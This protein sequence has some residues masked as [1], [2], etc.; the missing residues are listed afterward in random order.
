MLAPMVTALLGTPAL[1]QSA[2]PGPGGGT[3]KAAHSGLCLAV[4]AGNRA[5]GAAVTQQPCTGGDEQIWDTKPQRSGVAYV[6]RMSGKC[7]NVSGLTNALTQA[8]TQVFQ[9]TCAGAANDTWT[10]QAQTW[11]SGYRLVA[12]VSGMCLNVSGAFTSVGAGTIQWP[13]VGAANETFTSTAAGRAAAPQSALPG[14]GGGTLKAAHSG[15]CLAVAAGNR[16]DGA[17]ITQQPCTG[18]DEQIW[19]TKPQRSGVAY[20]NRMSGK[21]LNVSGLTNALTQAGTQ[22]FQWTCAGAANDTWTAQAQTWGSG[23]R[24][25]A[26]VSGM[27]LNVN[28]AF[29]SVGAGTIQWPCVGAVNETFSS[30]PAAGMGSTTGPGTGTV[31]GSGSGTGGGSTGGGGGGTVPPGDAPPATTGLIVA[32]HSAMC[33]EN[34]GAQT[35][36]GVGID[37]WPCEPGATHMDWTFVPASTGYQIRN[38]KSGLCLTVT[39]GATN[40]GAGTSQQS[41]DAST[42][43]GLW[44]LRKVGG[45]YEIVAVHSGRCLTVSSASR[46]NNAAVIQWDCTLQD[47]TVFALVPPAPPSAWTPLTTL[48]LV[49]VSATVMPSGKVMLWAAESRTSFGSGNGTWITVYDPGT[50]TSNDTYVSNTNHDMFCVGT[51]LLPDGRMMITGGITAGGTSLYNPDTNQWSTGPTLTIPRGYN[52]NVTLSTGETMTYGGSWSG[53]IG[54]KSAEVWSA[55]ARSWRVL[56]NVSGDAAAEPGVDLYRADNH[57]WLFGVSNGYVFHAGPSREMHW[58]GTGGTGSFASAGNRADDAFSINGTATMF[59]VNRI[60]KAGGAPQYQYQPANGA[61]YTIDIGRGPGSTPT[62]AAAAPLQF[63]RAFHNSVVLPSGD[64]IVVGG[65]TVPIPFTDSTPIYYPELWSPTKNTVVRL[66]PISVPRTYHSIALLLPDGRVLSAGGGL[67]N[68]SADHPNLQILTPPYL[69]G[70]NGQLASRPAITAA[71]TAAALG[72]T[73]KATTDR[74]VRS[75]ALVRLGSTTHT[76]NNDQRRVPLT[77]SGSNGTQY[78]LALPSDPGIVTPGNW[79]LFALDAGGVPSI[80]KIMRI[81]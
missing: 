74:A 71:P 35:A 8:G 45:F 72:S 51:N 13:C 22:V 47:N 4:A 20:V 17:A 55:A 36:A 24:L 41:C 18:G 79:M 30:A 23:Y 25:V 56:T 9:W 31:G 40:N 10:A 62:V 64:V 48:G 43:G 80:A 53:N 29:T 39:N 54:G 1:A 42:T 33:V 44:T 46:D 81:R 6:N 5:D 63:A 58:I 78:I 60:F 27:C 28:G 21:C 37:Q 49:P 26:E 61:T 7:L 69:Y 57:F 59:D 14:P 11:G 16:A 77:I 52:A 66:A 12:E 38:A 50:G 65:Q 3:L 34:P 75:F 15:L 68:C 73:I 32:K 19:D 2:L 76:V 67:C 70:A